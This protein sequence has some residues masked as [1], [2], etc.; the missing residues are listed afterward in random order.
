MLTVGGIVPAVP[1]Y[2]PPPLVATGSPYAS[3]S[4][5]IIQ[6]LPPQSEPTA[7][8]GPSPT[9]IHTSSTPTPTNHVQG[10]AKTAGVP[11]TRSTPVP[12]IDTVWA[13]ALQIANEKLGNNN[14]S[15]T[16]LTSQLPGGDI[17]AVIEALDTLRAAEKDKR[18]HWTWNGKRDIIVES[19]GKILKIA[20]PYSGIVDTSIQ[21]KPGPG[22]AALA[23]AG[24]WAIIR[25]CIHRQLSRTILILW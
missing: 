6:V 24:L 20:E 17:R 18:W 2:S 25:V 7:S 9:S 19:L 22:V 14:L 11:Q 21:S 4:A 15:L 12:D 10:P 5:P 16:N 3:V 8:E 1:S 23:W 13:E